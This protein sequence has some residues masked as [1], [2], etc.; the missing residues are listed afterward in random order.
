[1]ALAIIS[2]SAVRADIVTIT[3][4]EFDVVYDTTKLGLFD[5][6]S[7]VGNNLFFTPTAFDAQS[8]NGAGTV[9]TPSQASG[10]QLIAHTGYTFGNL[11]VAALGDYQM[12]GAG[13]SVNI[14]GMLTASDDARASTLTV[15]NLAI[16]ASTPLNIIDGAD[17][18]WYGTASITDSTPTVSPGNNPWLSTAKTIDLA[19]Q[20][21]LW[22]TTSGN[23]GGAEQAFI[24]EK[25][26]GVELMIDPVAVPVPAS[27]LL[28][29][30]GLAGLASWRRKSRRQA[31]SVSMRVSHS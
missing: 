24:E 7:L 4:S 14:T 13:S 31:A 6:P 18:N 8:L 2:A 17:H 1:M 26:S 10:I 3:G 19:L 29:A 15:A 25:F 12:S 27:F 23:T 21:T 11:S 20:N 5:T 30:S 16:S 22:A 9:D 28:L